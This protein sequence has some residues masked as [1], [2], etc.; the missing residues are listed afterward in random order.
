MIWQAFTGKVIANLK[1]QVSFEIQLT[2]QLL[3]FT[4]KQI[5]AHSNCTQNNLLYENTKK[6]SLGLVFLLL[7]KVE[8]S[9]F[10]KKIFIYFNENSFRNDK[11]WFFFLFSRFFGH[12]GKTTWLE[13]Y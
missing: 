11:K 7:I 1:K 6:I 3:S 12:I 5:A 13:R 2:A 9:S 8:L 4:L 10:K